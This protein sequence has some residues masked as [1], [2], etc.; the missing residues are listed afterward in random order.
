MKQ[1]FLIFICL[2]STSLFSQTKGKVTY[3]VKLDKD[4]IAQPYSD[5]GIWPEEDEALDMIHNSKPVNAFLIFKDSIAI[6]K[7]ESNTEIPTWDNTDGKIE[8]TKAGVNLTWIMAGGDNMHYTDWHREYNI[9]STNVLHTKYRIEGKT[10][11]W[12]ISEETKILNGYTCYRAE[13]KSNKKIT[14]W[15]TPEITVK[16]G[17]KGFNGLPGLVLELT[18]GRFSWVVDEIDF[19]YS[20]FDEIREPIGGELLSEDEY[21]KMGKILFSDN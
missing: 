4:S 2:A 6:Y 7:V 20:E 5:P 19:E 11:E 14:A 8:V 1:I 10:K 15:F 18:R 21:K 13:L 16:H 3:I 17:P 9:Y 12:L